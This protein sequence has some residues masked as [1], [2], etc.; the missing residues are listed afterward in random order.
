MNVE[1]VVA[2]VAIAAGVCFAANAAEWKT[3]RDLPVSAV[4]NAAYLTSMTERPWWNKAW[5]R[6][7]PILVSSAAKASCGKIV[8]DAVVDFGEQV[9]PAEVRL[10]TPW[11]TEVPCWVEAKEGTKLELYFETDL[12]IEENR[13]FLVYW[14]NPAAKAPDL[15]PTM[16]MRVNDEEV[17]IANGVLD[18]TFD[19]LHR[20]SGLLKKIRVLAS[21]T[22]NELLDR[23]SGFAWD[24]FSLRS[25][26]AEPWSKA[27]VVADNPFKKQIRFDSKKVTLDFT[28]YANQPRVDYA[29]TLKP[30][31]EQANISISWA[32]GDG[33]G[34]DDLF[35]PGLAGKVLSLRASLDHATDCIPNPHY[36]GLGKYLAEGWYAIRDRKQHEVVGM[37]FDRPTLASFDYSG[38][39]QYAGERSVMTFRH[40]TEKDR[41]VG[42]SGALVALMGGV[43]DVRNEYLRYC[44]APIISVGKTEAY[45]EIA[46]RRPRIDRDFCADYNIGKGAGAGW[47]SGEPLEGGEW[48]SNIVDRVRSLGGNIVRIGG[49]GWQD[50]AITKELYDRIA[51]VWALPTSRSRNRKMPEWQEGQYTG[52]KFR[53]H[54]AAAHAKGV[55][56]SLW[57]G[58]V[59]GVGFDNDMLWDKDAQELD[60]ELQC[61]YADLGADIIYNAMACREG[62]HIPTDVIK[63]RG[64]SWWLWDDPRD[65]F[66]TEDIR[67]EAIKKFYRD[68]K[69]RHPDTPVVVM[70]SECSIIERETMMTDQV[71]AFDSV[72]CEM[73]PLCDNPRTLPHTKMAVKRLRA[74]YDNEAGR[75]VHAHFYYYGHDCVQRILQVELPY[76]WGINGFTFE[77]LTYEN[78]G[79]EQPNITAD[80]YRFLEY[81]KL[82]DKVARMAPVKDLAVFRDN[83]AYVDDVINHRRGKPY[84]YSTQQDGRANA[85]AEIRN[86]VY[87]IVI[88]PFFTAKALAKYRAVYVPEDLSFGEDRAKELIGYVQAGG[89]AI[90][91]GRTVEGNGLSKLGLTDGKVTDLGKGKI[92]WLKDVL[93]DRL[94]RRDAKA[95]AQAK[96]LMAS[97]GCLAPFTLPSKTLDANLQISEEGMFLGVFNDGKEE[98]KG[99]ATLNLSHLPNFSHL[100]NPL[101]VLDVKRGVR[102]RYTNG[103]EVVVGP[104][105]CGYYLIGDEKFTALPE[106]SGGAWFGASASHVGEPGRGCKMPVLDRSEAFPRVH[107]L[108]YVRGSEKKPTMIRRSMLAAFDIKQVT[109]DA[110]DPSLFAAA[111]RKA[112]YLHLCANAKGADRAFADCPEELKAMLKRGG[113]I[114]FDR[115]RPGPN[116][117]KFLKEIGVF[118]PYPSA[119]TKIGDGKSV[120]DETF[121]SNHLLSA[122]NRVKEGYFGNDFIRRLGRDGGRYNLAFGQWDA[123]TQLTP[124]RAALNKD[125]THLIIQEHVLGAGKVAFNENARSF[126]DWYESKMYGDAL[127][128]WLIGMPVKDY[129]DKAE[130]YNGGPG[131]A[132]E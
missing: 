57:S 95:F 43:D 54:C 4:G 73:L 79:K 96:E 93:T 82:G 21:Q 55:A 76:V 117:Q 81:T 42:G 58:F 46:V 29:Y 45:R 89:G 131:K 87:D 23:A 11:E 107:A 72:Y 106:T 17:R 105:Q 101:Y 83:R 80:A 67:T 70:N 122:F 116:A 64:T 123:E 60:T 28:L 102:F 10:V 91:E 16:T 2:T 7:T 77:N 37:I 97:V 66:K 52:E 18:V 22:P 48:C 120:W 13:P 85:I 125:Y 100:S 110:Y 9:N 129:K 98:D 119:K 88:D 8:V 56:V 115:T 15:W 30:G 41:P 38:A 130:R 118:D 26:A 132:V 1:K 128:S 84:A 53:Q 127:L 124:F 94:A 103:F 74:L 104:E 35:Y 112:T 49:Y 51:K 75:T 59:P 44:K 69:R 63:G 40:Q 32:C 50:L 20:T 62:A 111:I 14:G 71:G 25:G 12:R 24:G 3:L 5:T 34:E 78:F 86:C 92:V 113:A 27:K 6:R 109:P 68:C 61:L 39:G 19:N 108:E 33:T 47:E 121:P 36:E 65:F 126:N 99:R 114:L 31:N 90:V